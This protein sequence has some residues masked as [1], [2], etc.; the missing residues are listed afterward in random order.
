MEK[1]LEKYRAEKAKDYQTVKSK[2][3]KW[4]QIPEWAKIELS[5]STRVNIC[6]FI[7]KII[8]WIL[9]WCF[10][11]EIEFGT[12]FLVF[13]MFYFVYTSMKEGT[14][15]PWEPSAYSVFNENFEEIDG[16]LNAEQFERELKF[17][18]GA[19]SKK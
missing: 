6:L 4:I 9:L 10:F 16:T 8:F 1:E 11:V 2:C 7:L 13:S 18:A 5:N 19:V 14:R 17:G 3:P 12:V 15:K